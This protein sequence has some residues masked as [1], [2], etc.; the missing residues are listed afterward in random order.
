MSDVLAEIVAHKRAELERVKQAC[1]AAELERQLS[2]APAVRGFAAALADCQPIGLIAEVKKSSPSA[3]LL[4]DA[5]DPASIAARYER[6]GAT[7][8]S[9]LTDERYFQGSLGDLKAVRQAISLPVLRKDFLVDR[10][11]VLEARAAGADCI[12]LIAECLDDCRMRD[13]YFYASDLGMDSLIEVYEAENLDRVL[14]LEP[15]LVGV[16]NRNLRTFET[17]LGHT[18]RLAPRIVGQALLVSESGI[19]TRA[20]VLDLQHAGV[21]G[22]LVGETLMRADNLEEKIGELLLR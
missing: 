2:A 9:V 18:L 11:Q 14:K 22:I 16:N 3:G 13:L 1:P 20:D 19:R 10:Y 15:A 12:L 21:Q 4:C 17:D 5:F 7:C 6:F 8:V